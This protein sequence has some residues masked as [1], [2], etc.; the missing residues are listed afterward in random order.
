MKAYDDAAFEKWSNGYMAVLGN[1]N[2]QIA[3]FLLVLSYAMTDF[4]QL[5]LCL[6]VACISF[7]IYAVT[8]PIGIMVDMGVFNFLMALLNLRHATE[9]VYR[10]RY[11][12]FPEEQEQI[13][14]TLFSQ[15]MTRVQF[16]A[17]AD[18]SVIRQEKTKVT[19]KKEGDLVTSLC[20]L[21]KGQVE[22]RRK[23]R[24]LN[25]LYKNEILEAPEWVRSNLD[26][27]GM[28]FTVSFTTATDVVYIKYTREL[29]VSI[30][31]NDYAIRNAVLAVLGI[32]VSEL[33]LRGLDRKMLR[34]LSIP[35][36]LSE[37]IEQ[38]HGSSGGGRVETKTS[39]T[40]HLLQARNLPQR[41]SA[42]ESS[43]ECEPGCKSDE[44]CKSEYERNSEQDETSKG[45][46]QS[47]VRI[48]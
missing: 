13:Y 22:V 28:R 43:S 10:K 14:T 25:V 27:E 48:L 34:V 32:R 18:I 8:S 19:M 33:W 4:L 24:I 30:L 40:D 44:E 37:K 41:R 39:E 2:L 12:E 47:T 7:V 38:F 23:E 26:P 1:W 16:K 36:P 46:N 9:L 21:V 35:T 15:Y 45:L 3:D 31:K 20:I 17:L 29:L 5:R 42:L 6:S 11:I